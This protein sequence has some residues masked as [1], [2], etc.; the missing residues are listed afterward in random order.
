MASPLRPRC[1]EREGKPLRIVDP[2]APGGQVGRWC[3]E[4]LEEHVDINSGDLIYI[5]VGIPHLPYN[6]SETETCTA[7]IARTDPNSGSR[8]ARPDLDAFYCTVDE[9]VRSTV[10]RNEPEMKWKRKIFLVL[11][12]N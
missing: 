6:P 9:R 7:V 5:P 4:R 2:Q 8:A 3:G 1:F 10:T 12:D 11:F